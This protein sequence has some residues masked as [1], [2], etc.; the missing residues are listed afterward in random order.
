MHPNLYTHN[1]TFVS[2]TFTS[3]DLCEA[4]DYIDRFITK[5][6][7][8]VRDCRNRISFDCNRL[9][10]S[11]LQICNFTYG[12]ADVDVEVRGSDEKSFCLIVPTQGKT[13][14]TRGNDKH[15]ISRG[16]ALL[17][18][19]SEDAI[20]LNTDG[21]RNLN[22][23]VF[24]QEMEKFLSQEMDL[25]IRN[26]LHFIKEPFN[27][28]AEVSSLLY[29]IAWVR[30]Q[31][32]NNSENTI[33]NNPHLIRHTRDIVLSLL[34]S[35]VKNNYQE[36]YQSERVRPIA[37]G[38][39]RRAEEFMRENLCEPINVN[40]V[41][42]AVNVSRRT[43]SQG[44]ERYRNYTASQFLRE[45]R[46]AIVR[47]ELLTARERNLSVTEIALNCGFLHLSKFATAYRK[48]F[49]ENP[50]DTLRNGS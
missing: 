43:L 5:H 35:S 20:F 31:L 37:P 28:S 13:V 22:I 15:T 44:F 23:R 4:Q 36:I 19:T 26:E 32:G 1:L 6:H 34:L 29:Y 46:L 40:Q 50:S 10:I 33:R 47:K 12:E 21:Y 42:A 38:F 25:P 14:V 7:V 41:A 9:S 8:N 11:D 30:K 2:D 3:H 39:V 45:E 18:D 24:Y 48:R 17:I 27:V 49:G 16:M